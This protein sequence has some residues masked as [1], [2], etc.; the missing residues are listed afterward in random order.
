VT[1]SWQ[2]FTRTIGAL[3]AVDALGIQTGQNYVRVT[4][5]PLVAHLP[6]IPDLSVNLSS[7]SLSPNSTSGTSSE[8]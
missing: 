1:M 8:I 2:C 6:R 4:V 7:K 5:T 3:G